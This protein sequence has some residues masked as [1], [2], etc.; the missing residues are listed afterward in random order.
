MS[1]TSQ[2]DRGTLGNDPGEPPVDD[3]TIPGST[4][5]VLSIDWEAG[6][7]IRNVVDLLADRELSVAVDTGDTPA[8]D[9]KVLRTDDGIVLQPWNIEGD[10]ILQADPVPFDI[11]V[12]DGLHVY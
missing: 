11:E 2:Q 12:I 9:A 10:S 7:L 8:F 3:A 6:D 1:Q 5:F 4:G